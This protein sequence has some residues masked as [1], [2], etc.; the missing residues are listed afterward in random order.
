MP[1]AEDI[2]RFEDAPTPPG[3]SPWVA[4]AAPAGEIAIVDAD[5]RGR[6]CSAS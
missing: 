3:E 2:V 4:G 5:P 1:R 6:R